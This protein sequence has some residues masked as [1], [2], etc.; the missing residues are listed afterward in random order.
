VAFSTEEE[1]T[2]E[3]LKR[4]WN[5]SGKS[6]LLGVIVFGVGYLGWIQWQSMQVASSASASDIYEEIGVTVVLGPGVQ[7]DDEA[8]ANAKRLIAQLKEEHSTSVYA[9]YGALYGARLAVDDRDLNT[10]ESELQWLVDNAQSGLFSSTDESLLITAKLRLARVI[11]AK[12]EAPR[13]LALLAGLN[14]GAFEAEYE[15]IRGDVYVALGQM[16]EAQ[17]SYQAARDAGSTSDTLQ[18]KL[19]DIALES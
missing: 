8:V 18:M 17:A 3:T 9:L 14:P 1:E 16:T 2:L 12:G 19:D 10:A 4:W 5:E 6:L 7:L 11:L 15:E 13:A